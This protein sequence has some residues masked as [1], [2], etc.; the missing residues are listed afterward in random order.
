MLPQSP[1]LS[2]PWRKH[3][4]SFLQ[5][6]MRGLHD[7]L[8]GTSPGYSIIKPHPHCNHFS[9]NLDAVP[10]ALKVEIACFL[11]RLCYPTAPHGVKTLPWRPENLHVGDI[12][13]NIY[14]SVCHMKNV[15][16]TLL[17]LSSELIPWG[18]K[19]LTVFMC[20]FH[21]LEEPDYIFYVSQTHWQL[22]I[23][24]LDNNTIS[25]ETKRG[26]SVCKVIH[27]PCMWCVCV[28]AHTHTNT[29]K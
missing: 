29:P 1:K 2:F 3:F 26:V 23:I 18:I 8:R 12:L 17:F 13:W 28:S 5:G 10:A 22:S 9:V 11:K 14:I 4:A 20:Y 25:L 24:E 6:C 19:D 7:L 27:F 21:S 16:W 15:V